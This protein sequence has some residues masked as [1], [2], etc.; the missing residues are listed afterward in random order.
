MSV[1][2]EVVDATGAVAG[3]CKKGGQS[4]R[5]GSSESCVSGGFRV[6]KDEMGNKYRHFYLMT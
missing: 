6:E 5:G 1:C 3:H 2:G 4:C